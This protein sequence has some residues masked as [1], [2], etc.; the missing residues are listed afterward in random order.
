[1]A[2][3][4]YSICIPAT[5]AML[6]QTKQSCLWSPNQMLAISS[7]N[8]ASEIQPPLHISPLT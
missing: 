5:M 7:V 2:L 1:M 4:I 3:C 8:D 6:L